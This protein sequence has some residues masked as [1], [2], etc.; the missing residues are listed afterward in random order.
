MQRETLSYQA[1][2][3]TMNGELFFERSGA[4]RPGVLA[5]PEARL[6]NLKNNS[7]GNHYWEKL[8]EKTI[9]CALDSR[10]FSHGLS[11][12]SFFLCSADHVAMREAG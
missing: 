9:L 6:L 5:Y 10:T 11:R 12:Q 7:A 3:L 2:G 1:D 8:I 4:P